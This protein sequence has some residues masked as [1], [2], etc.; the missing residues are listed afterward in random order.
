MSTFGIFKLFV[1]A[2]YVWIKVLILK[3]PFVLVKLLLTLP[4]AFYLFITSQIVPL[5]WGA[6]WVAGGA[7]FGAAIYVPMALFEGE[8]IEF[9][10]TAAPGAVTGNAEGADFLFFPDKYDEEKKAAAEEARV[11]KAQEKE[12]KRV[13]KEQKAATKKAAKAK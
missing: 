7:A 6:A 10:A 2:L 8:D 11:R 3:V 1:K 12:A 9:G 4:K 13:A 5:M